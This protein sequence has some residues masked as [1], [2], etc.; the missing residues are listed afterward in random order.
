M[1]VLGLVVRTLLEDR[2]TVDLE[3]AG[4]VLVLFVVTH[5]WSS[6]AWRVVRNCI[7]LYCCKRSIHNSLTPERGTLRRSRN[8]R[9]PRQGPSN[10]P[11]T[12]AFQFRNISQEGRHVSC[13]PYSLFLTIAIMEGM[14]GMPGGMPDMPVNVPID[15]PNADTEW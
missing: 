12:R 5:S 7:P 3:Q 15:D 10:G 1:V 6:I 9:H 11:W 14:G 2:G 13:I 8:P 4:L